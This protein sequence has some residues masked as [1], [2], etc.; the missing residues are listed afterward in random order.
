MSYQE[1]LDSVW[2]VPISQAI[3]DGVIVGDII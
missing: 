1:L 2:I 3:I